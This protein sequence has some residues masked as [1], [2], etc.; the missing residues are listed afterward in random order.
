MPKTLYLVRHAKSSWKNESLSDAERP[1]NKRGKHDA[2]LMGS[3]LKQ[4]DKT[5]DV[6]ISS[7]AKRALSTAKL[8]AEE[9]GYAKKN[10][11]IMEELYMADVSDFLEI[12]RN[13]NDSAESIMLFS[14]NPGIT[15]FAN[16]IS[17][18]VIE[19]IPTAGT[20]RIDLNIKSWMET[21]KIKGTLI[22]FEYPKKYQDIDIQQKS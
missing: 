10:I 19:N 7:P 20:I 8:F 4:R 6:I 18:S 13:I 15:Y 17:G 14:H 9:L 16:F 12:I 5:P 22:F 3:I 11:V 1:L 21:G 2:P